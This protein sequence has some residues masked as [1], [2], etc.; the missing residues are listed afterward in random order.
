MCKY[1]LC[2]FYGKY[3]L[4]YNIMFINIKYIYNFDLN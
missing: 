2:L 4:I 3:L 1:I